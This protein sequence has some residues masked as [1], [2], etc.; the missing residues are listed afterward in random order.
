MKS[1]AEKSKQ[2]DAKRE[3]DRLS[4]Q[5]VRDNRKL[6]IELGKAIKENFTPAYQASLIR[7]ANSLKTEA[8][9]WDQKTLFLS[10][11]LDRAKFKTS[12]H[13]VLVSTID[14]TEVSPPCSSSSS[15]PMAR[16]K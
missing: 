4:Q 9:L 14:T 6:T 8:A 3:K 2:T 15:T 10:Q 16:K 11:V 7:E 1:G 12:R 5:I 13:G